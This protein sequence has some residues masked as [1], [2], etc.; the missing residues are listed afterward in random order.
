[1]LT[2]SH[3][4][5]VTRYFTE[6]FKNEVFLITEDKAILCNGIMLAA[7]STV[8]EEIIRN[9]ENIPAIEFSDN[10]DGLFICLNLIYGGG[11]EIN[12]ESYRSVFKFGK[13]FQIKEMMDGVLKWVTEELPSTIFW[14]VYF[15]VAKLDPTASTAAFQSAIKRYCFKN[16]NDFL[17]GLFE[18]C[19]NNE[20]NFKKV[21]EFVISLSEISSFGI[22][23]IFGFMFLTGTGLLV[24]VTD[25]NT[26]SSS[27]TSTFTTHVDTIISGAVEYIEKEM[28][29]ILTW[30][31]TEDLLKLF[32]NHC[33]KIEILRK[34]AKLQSLILHYKTQIMSPLNDLSQWLIRDLASP[35]TS[36]G[37]ITS[38]TEYKGEILHP[39]ITAEIVLEWWRARKGECLD[40]TFIKTL[41]SKVQE[42]YSGWVDNVTRDSRYTE[43]VRGLGLEEPA[44]KRYFCYHN[45]NSNY[46]LI[47]ILLCKQV[48][49][50][51]DGTP[52]ILPVEDINCTGN[53]AVYKH[54][55]PAFR[56]NPAIVPKYGINDG[57]WYLECSYKHDGVDVHRFVSFI[58]S[59]NMQIV[60]SLG[61]CAHASLFYVPLP[62][63]E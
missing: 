51:A 6:N 48:L 24:V 14:E 63:R 25:D 42:M 57:H 22:M 1:M 32:I 41:F 12:Q 40:N 4:G 13:I 31:F 62:D 2:L 53:M 47:D 38:F 61:N 11:V 43:M 29:D 27:S 56:Y 18:A 46:E 21:M 9:S 19:H 30:S 60:E 33:N 37:A 8:I 10:I 26:A 16:F 34:I 58:T 54:T 23:T 17:V 44:E 39:C 7:R 3:L 36:Y 35:S 52:L 49:L 45:P 55:V 15:D 28:G 59:S 5:D 50:N 20:E